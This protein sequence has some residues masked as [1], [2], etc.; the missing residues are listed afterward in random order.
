MRGEFFGKNQEFYMQAIILNSE[1]WIDFCFFRSQLSDLCVFGGEC[2]S[3]QFHTMS[4]TR[5]IITIYNEE[6]KN[7]W[8][9]NEKT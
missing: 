4:H 8:K 9:K 2:G 3:Y 7:D 6:M 5:K 1:L